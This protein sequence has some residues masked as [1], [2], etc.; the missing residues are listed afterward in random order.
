M[1]KL[2]KERKI[3]PYARVHLVDMLRIRSRGQRISIRSPLACRY[4]ERRKNRIVDV[5]S[6]GYAPEYRPTP[7]QSLRQRQSKS[8]RAG[9]GIVVRKKGLATIAKQ[10]RLRRESLYRSPSGEFSPAF[11]TVMN[12]AAN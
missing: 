6:P 8:C 11:R 4:A 5:K 2:T 3:G 7:L 12:V 1:T 10:A 9:P